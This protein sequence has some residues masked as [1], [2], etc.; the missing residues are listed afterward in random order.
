MRSGNARQSSSS[1]ANKLTR[2]QL[3]RDL[4]SVADPERANSLAWF[5]KTGKGG[6][7]Q[8]DRFLGIPVPL[9]RKIALRYRTLALNDIARLLASRIHEHRFAALEILV[10]QYE[11]GYE[12]Q[13]EEIFDFFLRHSARV[14]NCDLVDTSAPYIAGEHLRARGRD[15][16]YTLAR[17]PVVWERRI[18]IVSTLTFIGT[19]KPKIRFASL[20]Y[21]SPINTT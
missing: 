1:S 14:N 16:L 17:S 20:R 6:Y 18:A 4:N 5:F 21:F 11:T 13:R 10:A 12:A 19:A 9:Q 15:V 7:G 8:G 3:K 2:E